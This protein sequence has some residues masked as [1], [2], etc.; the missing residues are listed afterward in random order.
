[1]NIQN[2]TI[3]LRIWGMSGIAKT[4]VRITIAHVR[5]MN[6]F[7]YRFDDAI[8]TA[9]HPLQLDSEEIEYAKQWWQTDRPFPCHSDSARL[10]K[11]G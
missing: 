4:A 10:R 11:T 8:G 1:M 3:Q 2:L 6:R 7:E 9:L 5:S